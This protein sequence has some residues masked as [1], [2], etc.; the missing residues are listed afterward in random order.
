[1]KQINKIEQEKVCS[2]LKADWVVWKAFS[3]RATKKNMPPQ[4][5]D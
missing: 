2:E 4:P 1:M 5:L 3:Y